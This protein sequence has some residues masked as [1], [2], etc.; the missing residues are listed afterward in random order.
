MPYKRGKKWVGKIEVDGEVIYTGTNHP[1][2][3]AAKDAEKE[4][5]DRRKNRTLGGRETCSSFAKRWTTDYPFGRNRRR[6]NP[7]TVA[8][9]DY[10]VS[11]FAEHPD[12]K[13]TAIEDVTRPMAMAYAREDPNRAKIVATMFADIYNDGLVP[14]NHWKSLGLPESK[15]TVDILTREEFDECCEACERLFGSEYGPRFRALFEFAAW[16]GMRPGELFALRRENLEPS[17]NLVHVKLQTRR[18]GSQRAPKNYLERTVILPDQAIEAYR[19]LPSSVD[20][21][22]F[23][24]KTWQPM[25]QGILNKDWVEVRAAIGRPD[26]RW[27]DATKH[28]CGSQLA[29]AGLAPMYIGRQLGHTDNGETAKKHYIHLYPKVAH[30]QT[31]G[32]FRALGGRNVTPLRRVDEQAGA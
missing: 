29:M 19:R 16:T 27:Y 2:K 4:E 32:A 18:N 20:G 23:F 1:T 12:F 22:L 17:K 14:H 10:M 25:T 7:D 13:D 24:S 21:M 5:R 6:R 9:Y 3:T 8:N 30:S 26:L 28:F 15:V 31:L 11:G